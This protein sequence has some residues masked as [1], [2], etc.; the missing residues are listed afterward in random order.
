MFIST[1]IRELLQRL[2]GGG[3]TVSLIVDGVV[4]TDQKV[5]SVTNDL[6]FTVNA[7]GVVRATR[8][9]EIDSINY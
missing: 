4:I 8:L 5:V 9:A 6:V 7:A 3:F 2:I 1:S